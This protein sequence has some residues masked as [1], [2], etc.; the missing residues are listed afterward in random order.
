MLL[1]TSCMYMYMY[2]FVLQ[3]VQQLDDFGVHFYKVFRSKKDT[4]KTTSQAFWT[5]I[6]VQGI[7]TAEQQGV[8]R[9]VTRRH[10][11]QQTQKISFKRKRFSIKPKPQISGEK[12]AKLDY[13]TDSHKK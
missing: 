4:G 2:M 1:V 11:W 7:I 8:A 13:Y 9:V 6:S 10:P 3:L 12:V 5:G